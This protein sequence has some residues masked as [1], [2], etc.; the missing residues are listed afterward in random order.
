[1]AVS[2]FSRTKGRC[3]VLDIGHLPIK[4]LARPMKMILHRTFSASDILTE[5]FEN[6]LLSLISYR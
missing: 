1:M 2:N 5:D 4:F 3:M 6:I